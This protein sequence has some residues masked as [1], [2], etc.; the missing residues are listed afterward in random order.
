MKK[1]IIL[2]YGDGELANQLWN[3]IS[4]YAYGLEKNIPVF[5]PSFYEYHVHFKLVDRESWI[6]RLLAKLFENYTN[7]KQGYLKKFCRKAYQI[8]PFLIKIISKGNLISSDDPSNKIIYLPPTN[9]DFRSNITNN[10]IYFNGWLFR[11]PKGLEKYR[12]EIIKAFCPKDEITERVHGIISSL[13]AKYKKVIGL[14]IRQGDYKTFKG[15]QYFVTEKRFREIVDEYVKRN[16]IDSNSTCFLITSDGPIDPKTFNGLNIYIS[17]ENAVTDLFLLSAT[18]TIIGSD[19]T[20][21][22]FASWYGDIPH[23]I[24]TNNPIDWNYYSTRRV[25]F[26]NKY[27]TMVHY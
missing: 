15:G 23:I 5:N 18:D 12:N 8:Y 16:G 7:R 24:A 9:L 3:Y 2:R 11:N 6:I 13:F 20:F 26:E 17:K 14:H 25:Y 22:D 21:G 27:C 4:I 10:K 1:I 19:S